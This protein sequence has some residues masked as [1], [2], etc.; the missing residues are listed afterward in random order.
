[1][2][3]DANGEG[4]ERKKEN[5]WPNKNLR[6][7]DTFMTSVLCVWV[8]SYILTEDDKFGASILYLNVFDD[9]IK[10]FVDLLKTGRK[11]VCWQ[12]CYWKKGSIRAFINTCQW[13]KFHVRAKKDQNSKG[14]LITDSWPCKDLKTH[15]KMFL[16]LL[17]TVLNRICKAILQHYLD[18]YQWFF[19]PFLSSQLS[20]NTSLAF[21]LCIMYIGLN[22]SFSSVE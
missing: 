21:T 12:H 7:V 16:S 13:Q 14:V 4:K 15:Q 3:F 17:F 8:L 10:G 9:I 19:F 1:M 5:E 2:L 11:C 20:Q 18:C 22:L 6:W